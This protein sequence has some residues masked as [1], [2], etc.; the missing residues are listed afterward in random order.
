MFVLGEGECCEVEPGCAATFPLLL[1]QLQGRER[2]G[3]IL[4]RNVL[5]QDAVADGIIL[6]EG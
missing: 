3:N 6:T 2:R 1:V 5:L 4:S